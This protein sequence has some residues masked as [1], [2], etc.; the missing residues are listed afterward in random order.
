MYNPAI[1]FA[2]SHC[3][4]TLFRVGLLFFFEIFFK[5]LSDLFLFIWTPFLASHS[6]VY[7]GPLTR[8]TFTAFC[9]ILLS[10]SVSSSSFMSSEAANSSSMG[11]S[12]GLPPASSANSEEVFYDKYSLQHQN[13][14]LITFSTS[15]S[16]LPEVYFIF[17]QIQE[18]WLQPRPN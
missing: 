2:Y 11:T 5:K 13:D 17:I 6:T 12:S 4:Q 7:L 10:S 1:L 16:S 8:A 14:V 18:Q 9:K 15:Q 3:F